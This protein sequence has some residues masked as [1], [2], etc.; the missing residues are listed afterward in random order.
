M[1]KQRQEKI[2]ELV[3]AYK[4]DTQDELIRRLKESG[5]SATNTFHRAFLSSVGMTPLQFR[6]AFREDKKRAKKKISEI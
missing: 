5:F 3:D 6:R 2:K 4:I 1:K